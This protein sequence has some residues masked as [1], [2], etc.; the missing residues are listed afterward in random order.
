MRCLFAEE[1]KCISSLLPFPKKGPT[2][3]GVCVCVYRVIPFSVSVAHTT[4]AHMGDDISEVGYCLRSVELD[5][6]NNVPVFVF[7][8]GRTNPSRRTS[9]GHQPIYALVF[10]LDAHR[11]PRNER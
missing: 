7:D 4:F 2:Q 8:A 5:L 9:F 11:K 1:P 10:I 3:E 6:L